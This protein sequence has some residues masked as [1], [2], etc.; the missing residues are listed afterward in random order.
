MRRREPAPPAAALSSPLPSSASD[1]GT[2]S[3]ASVR[4]ESSQ[5]AP[6]GTGAPSGRATWHA[7]RPTTLAVASLVGA[8]CILSVRRARRK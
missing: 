8:A 6:G 5:P 1:G 2:R 4:V 7:H 3:P